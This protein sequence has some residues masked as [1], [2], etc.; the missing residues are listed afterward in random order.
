MAAAKKTNKKPARKVAKKKT[1]RKKAPSKRAAATDEPKRGKG[2]PSDF[3]ERF[4]GEAYRL[5]LLFH[6]T[7]K[8]LAEYFGRAESTINL[9]KKEHPAFAEA[10]RKGKTIADAEVAES[11]LKKAKGFVRETT[12][13]VL[14]KDATEKITLV[15][16]HYYPPETQAASLWLRNRQPEHW[17]D[18]ISHEHGGQG[19]GPIPTANVE[20]TGMEA[21]D[22]AKKY[23]DFIE[24]ID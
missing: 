16:E 18:K 14:P 21:A 3:E 23:K 4:I 12:K 13:D 22:A 8:D 1:T 19:G 2:R 10:V 5:C 17:R 6:A 7:D 11:L 24:Q 9:W 15:E 20:L